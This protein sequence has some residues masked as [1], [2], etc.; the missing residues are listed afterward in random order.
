LE[1]RLRDTDLTG[2]RGR[3]KNCAYKIEGFGTRFR[4]LPQ[5]STLVAYS[6]RKNSKMCHSE[7]RSVLNGLRNLLFPWFSCEQQIPHPKT[8]RVRDDKSDF[9]RSLLVVLGGFFFGVGD[10]FFVGAFEVVDFAV[11][12][13]P[14]AGGDLVDYV[15]VVGDEED[16]AVVALERDV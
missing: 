9:F 10:E 8:T 4:C 16:G 14:D 15:V 2:T 1:G 12:E 3:A 6:L 7:P 5:Q 11:A 13:M